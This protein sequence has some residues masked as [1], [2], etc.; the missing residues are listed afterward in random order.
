[1]KRFRIRVLPA[2]SGVAALLLLLLIAPLLMPAHLFAP[3]L[4]LAVSNRL[5][6]PVRIGGARLALL[7]LPHA[8]ITDIDIGRQP[9]MRV[10]RLTLTPQ[11]LSL[12]SGPLILRSVELNGVQIRQQALARIERWSAKRNTGETAQVTVERVLLQRVDVR[13]DT[14]TLLGIDVDVKLAADG[15]LR[16]ALARADD[17]HLRLSLAPS[18]S[19]IEV[20]LSATDW[21][22]PI[23]PGIRFARLDGQGKLNRNGLD[24]DSID[25]ELYEGSLRGVARL[26]W[27]REWT[28]S[29]RVDLK[30][31]SVAPFAALYARDTV[32]SGQLDASSAFEASSSKAA[33]LADSLRV[34]ADFQLHD[35][36]LHKVDLAAAATLIP[37][38]QEKRK[39]VTHFDRFTG[40]LT[41]DR[42]GFHFSDVQIVSGALDAKGYVT[43][44]PDKKLSGRVDTAL[45]GTGSLV[46]TPLAISGTLE[47]PTVLPTKG[48]LAGAAAGTLLLGPGIG[49]TIGIKAGQLTE[50]LFGKKPP[51]PGLSSANGENPAEPAKPK[52]KQNSG[53]S[54]GR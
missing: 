32:I 43:I 3:Q 26:G 7:P 12:V 14:I 11:L 31:M 20:T 51:K 54:G 4:A 28:L 41:V 45:K 49:T 15:T 9:F 2:V 22:L 29:G 47:S 37:T 44:A 27:K 38:K 25:G 21:R 6:E 39:G 52:T 24:L 13:L 50:R 30:Q 34:E 35:G 53:P 16:S 8:A 33:G 36:V 18:D 5:G 19:G 42:A 40:H 46:G 1:M 10:E 23:E 17:G 48:T